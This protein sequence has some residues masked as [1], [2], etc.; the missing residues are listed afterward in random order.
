MIVMRRTFAA[1]HSFTDNKA[2]SG[3]RPWALWHD[4]IAYF[5][6]Q[7]ISLFSFLLFCDRSGVDSLQTSCRPVRSRGLCALADW[8][9]VEK[10]FP[11]R[12]G[13]NT[14]F[15]GTICCFRVEKRS[16]RTLPTLLHSFIL[17]R[18]K[19]FR[20]SRWQPGCPLTCYLLQPGWKYAEGLQGQM[21]NVIPPAS[22][23]P[24]PGSRP[25]LISLNHF[26]QVDSGEHRYQMSRPLRLHS[27]LSPNSGGPSMILSSVTSL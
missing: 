10:L 11:L 4:K 6:S 15:R 2:T 25:S 27:E 13:C 24:A 17:F 12:L 19:P 3:A 18:V 7:H 22:P 21:E 1:A 20:W 9:E 16:F 23:R 26:P 14:N 5:L 8:L